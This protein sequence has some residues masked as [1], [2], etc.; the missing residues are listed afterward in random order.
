MSGTEYRLHGSPRTLRALAPFLLLALLA[1]TATAAPARASAPRASKQQRLVK[2]LARTH[3]VE[4]R[5]RAQNERWGWLTHRKARRTARSEAHQAIDRAVEDAGGQL[6]R[7]A[8]R[9]LRR[10]MR[11]EV[12]GA[13]LEQVMAADPQLAT[14]R[15]GWWSMLRRVTGHERRP[16]SRLELLVDGP[17][18]RRATHDLVGRAQGFLH[19][20]GLEWRNDAEGHAFVHAIAAR[21]LRLK[22]ARLRRLLATR[23]LAEVRDLRLAEVSGA[24]LAEIQA[25]PESERRAMVD[26]VLDP[27]EV[28]V[29]LAGM[30][31]LKDNRGRPKP[32]HLVGL[33]TVGGH[34][35]L[36]HMPLQRRFPFF[37]P[38][39]LYA[40]VT[41]GKMVVSGDEAIAGGQNFG[42]KYQQPEGAPLVWHD[43][44]AEFQGKVVHDYTRSFIAHWNATAR[45][46]GKES[47][48]VDEARTRPASREKF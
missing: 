42:F 9:R 45:A 3:I 22:P 41:H 30:F 7:K 48:V 29:L 17:E 8:A 23:T 1:G 13:S 31:Q 35:L 34:V 38:Q 20:S 16:F 5:L 44:S 43:A 46:K 12:D 11:R 4:P 28:R 10:S 32:E 36:E 18:F 40:R 6:D 19:I 2:K 15:R 14:G 37:L 21:K 24:P 39:N 25:L 27:L 33:E 47:L 26:R